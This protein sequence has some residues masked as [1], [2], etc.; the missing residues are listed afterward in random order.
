M[1]EI[2]FRG[3]RLSDG[4][5]IY[6]YY[7][8]QKGAAYI[9]EWRVDSE[10]VGQYAFTE[11]GKEYYS[12]DTLR[13]NGGRIYQ[14]EVLPYFREIFSDKEFPDNLEPIQGELF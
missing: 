5:T 2:K 9:D 4:Q 1:R 8:V 10:T 7:H 6:G 3:V 14:V 11:N 12:G 13:R